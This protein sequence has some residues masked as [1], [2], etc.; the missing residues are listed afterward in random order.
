MN[1]DGWRDR[2]GAYT[3]IKFYA[4]FHI[5]AIYL[6]FIYAPRTPNQVD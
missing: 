2:Y 4:Y 5:S 6:L 3:R 1:R